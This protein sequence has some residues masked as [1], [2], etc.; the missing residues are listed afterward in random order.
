MSDK[1]KGINQAIEK[2]EKV[3][4]NAKIMPKEMVIEFNESLEIL[5]GID[6]VTGREIDYKWLTPKHIA[7][8]ITERIWGE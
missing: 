2:L 3:W 8:S 5:K 6:K 7:K 1:V 4:W